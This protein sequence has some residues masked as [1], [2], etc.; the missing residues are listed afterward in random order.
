MDHSY[1][2]SMEA[3][4]NKDPERRPEV[5]EVI[6]K[7][8]GLSDILSDS[9]PIILHED[10]DEMIIK[11]SRQTAIRIGGVDTARYEA[12]RISRMS[13]SKYIVKSYRSWLEYGPNLNERFGGTKFCGNGIVS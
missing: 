7:Y 11:S 8:I 3:M 1:N 4:T 9:K 5:G 2:E 13:R 12:D 6:R 10:S